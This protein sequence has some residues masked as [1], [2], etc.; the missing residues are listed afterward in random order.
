MLWGLGGVDRNDYNL[1]WKVKYKTGYIAC[2]NERGT[3]HERLALVI[4]GWW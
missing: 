1:R 2:V 4:Y 3:V